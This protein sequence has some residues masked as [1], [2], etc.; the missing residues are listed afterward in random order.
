L[1]K[2][3]SRIPQGHTV[4]Y[5]YGVGHYSVTLTIK[6]LVVSVRLL[7][8]PLIDII[9]CYVELINHTLQGL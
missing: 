7:A 3:T 4:A 9:Q 6:L 2:N 1:L 5:G 8:L